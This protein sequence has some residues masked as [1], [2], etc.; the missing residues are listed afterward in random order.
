MSEEVQRAIDRAN[1]SFSSKMAVV[2]KKTLIHDGEILAATIAELRAEI[3][4]EHDLYLTA[5]R[6]NMVGATLLMAARDRA[7]AAEASL[8]EKSKAL[9]EFVAHHNRVMSLPHPSLAAQA[10]E[11][12]TLREEFADHHAE[13]LA[14]ENVLRAGLEEAERALEEVSTAECSPSCFCDRLVE[15]AIA[16]LKTLA[17]APLSMPKV[18]KD[19]PKACMNCGQGPSRH[20]MDGTYACGTY[21]PP[22]PDSPA[23]ECRK[24]GT[25]GPSSLPCAYCVGAKPEPAALD[26]EK[27][28]SSSCCDSPMTN[29]G[30]CVTCDH[31]CTD[32]N[33]RIR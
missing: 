26:K 2:T 16:K 11:I 6:E 29:P 24:H 21:C 18:V 4:R 20:G 13:A 28:P 19:N 14:R 27:M 1:N 33:A 30:W 32:R 23:W 25:F 10:Q 9:E 22:A 3:V 17:T 15:A 31:A 5:H 8:A 7:T 12:K